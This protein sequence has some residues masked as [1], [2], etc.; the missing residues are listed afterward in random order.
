MTQVAL[1]IDTQPLWPD[2]EIKLRKERFSP[3]ATLQITQGACDSTW[4]QPSRLFEHFLHNRG[5]SGDFYLD[6][7]CHF[8]VAYV[9]AL[10]FEIYPKPAWQHARLPNVRIIASASTWNSFACG[11]LLA[12][13]IKGDPTRELTAKCLKLLV[14]QVDCFR[15]GDRGA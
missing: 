15:R 12:I 1:P 3:Y 11:T 7:P 8:S 6:K 4:R 10:T 14:E 13:Q 2:I 5:Y 9:S